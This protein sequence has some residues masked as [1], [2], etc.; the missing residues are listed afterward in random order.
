[1]TRT[2]LTIWVVIAIAL[3]IAIPA[4]AA[5][6]V[7]LPVVNV[8][9]QR[10]LTT[11]EVHFLATVPNGEIPGTAGLREACRQMLLAGIIHV[12]ETGCYQP[13][14]SGRYWSLYQVWTAAKCVAVP[15]LK[16]LQG[17]P[18]PAG[19]IGPSGLVGPQGPPG[20]AGPPATVVW[21]PLHLGGDPNHQMAVYVGSHSDIGQSVGWAR[22]RWPTR[23]APKEQPCGPGEPPAQ[24]PVPPPAEPPVP[25]PGS[26][27]SPPVPP[28]PVPQ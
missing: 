28:P 19:P 8:I 10:D 4:V 14:D 15:I 25:A 22:W 27:P 21:P 16:G 23:V 9:P 11:A 13:G 6:E 2:A 24:P 12:P 3:A 1:M 17:P 5:E 7:T 18:G 20:L 26:P